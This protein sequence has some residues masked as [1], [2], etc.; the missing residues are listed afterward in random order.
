MPEITTVE[1]KQA[2]SLA[3]DLMATYKDSEDL[4]NIGAYVKGSNTKIDNAIKYNDNIED[5]LKQG[6]NENTDFE[7]SLKCSEKYV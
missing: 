4:I 3:R 2:A 5:Y 7:V 6:T 1:H